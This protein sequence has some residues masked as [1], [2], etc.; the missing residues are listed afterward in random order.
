MAAA[1]SDTL[2]YPLVGLYFQ[3]QV[4]NIQG[5]GGIGEGSFQEVTGLSFKLGTKDMEEGGENRFTHKFP[6]QPKY[7]NLILKRGMLIGSP[8]I[9]WATD[10]VS[11]FKFKPK[12]VLVKLLAEGSGPS[13]LKVITTWNLV[14]AYPIAL[15][16]SDFKAQEGSIV[17]ETL[18]LCYD[19]F[20]TS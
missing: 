13:T 3:V 15:K 2:N 18:E 8:L 20:T 10:S 7:D 12:T 9:Q 6:T 19:Y 17:L 16:V 11:S 5:I 4:L 1:G 14:N